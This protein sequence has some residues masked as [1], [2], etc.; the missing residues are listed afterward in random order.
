MLLI[1]MS[2]AGTIPVVLCLILWLLMRSKFPYHLGKTLL[3]ISMIFYLLPIQI[4]KYLFPKHIFYRIEVD[5]V[6]RFFENYQDSVSIDL[7]ERSVWTPNWLIYILTGWLFMI[8]TFSMYQLVK[9]N[10]RVHILRKCSHERIVDIPGIG[11]REIRVTDCIS[12]PYTVGFIHMFIIFPDNLLGDSSSGMILRHEYTHLRKKDSLMKLI[13]L[14]IICIHWMNPSAI[15]LLVLY[16]VFSEFIADEA[17]T[18]GYTREEKKAYIKTM[19][20]T[21]SEFSQIPVVWKNDFFSSKNTLKRRMDYIMRKNMISKLTKGL[22][23]CAVA[24]SVVASSSTIFAYA[25]LQTSSGN[26]SEFITSDGQF[27]KYVLDDNEILEDFSDSDYIFITDAGTETSVNGNEVSPNALICIH[28]FSH[29]T[30]QKHVSNNS[31]GCTMY[32]YDARQC[33][34]CGHLEINDLIKTVTYV[35]CP[36]G[37]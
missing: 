5:A 4:I 18:D 15:L 6:T 10:H 7:G 34:K 16:S 37:Y 8:L 33:E 36:H 14:V 26:N 1:C 2:V 20:E 17:A 24:L 11:K 35:K 13:C 28:D 27:M 23:A 29:G 32:V 9:Y 30:L 21:A 31:G 19:I 12:N 3:V 25:P 22:A